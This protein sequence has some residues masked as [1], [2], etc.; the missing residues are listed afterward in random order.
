[1]RA[2]GGKNLKKFLIVGLPS[3]KSNMKNKIKKEK[4]RERKGKR[5]LDALIKFRGK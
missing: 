4:K 2:G 3:G 1:M 5:A